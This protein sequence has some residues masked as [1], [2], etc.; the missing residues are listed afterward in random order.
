MSYT[1][2]SPLKP[3]NH[4]SVHERRP[5]LGRFKPLDT[6]TAR[7]AARMRIDKACLRC[8]LMKLKV[9]LDSRSEMSTSKS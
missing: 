4:S 1:V 3:N 5:K 6:Q 8:K 2:N 9:T 7:E